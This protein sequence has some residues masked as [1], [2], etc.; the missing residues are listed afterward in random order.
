MGSIGWHHSHPVLRVQRWRVFPHIHT[1]RNSTDIRIRSG[2]IEDQ[3]IQIRRRLIARNFH[4]LHLDFRYPIHLVPIL[5]GNLFSHRRGICLLTQRAISF[6]S[7]NKLSELLWQA[8]FC[9]ALL[10]PS[11]P[12]TIET[13]ISSSLGILLSLRQFLQCF[14]TP[15]STGQYGL[16]LVGPSLSILRLSQF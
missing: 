9:I 8:I 4:L 1:L 13:W 3:K 10:D 14:S 6:S 7:S 5:Q 12:A 2:G 16:I 11:R 15:I